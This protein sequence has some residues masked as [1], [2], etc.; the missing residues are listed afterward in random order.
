[1]TSGTQWSRFFA[2]VRVQGVGEVGRRDLPDGQVGDRMDGFGVPAPP[3]PEGSADDLQDCVGVRG[4]DLGGDL[5]ELDALALGSSVSGIDGAVGDRD[6]LPGQCPE[7]TEQ[8]GLVGLDRE[9]EGPASADQVIDV[10]AL[11]VQRVSTNLLVWSTQSSSGAKASISLI[12]PSK[13]R[14]P[15]TTPVAVSNAASRRTARPSGPRA[16]GALAV[17]GD[18]WLVQQRAVVGRQGSAPAAHRTVH[19]RC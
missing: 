6:L 9:Q 5:G 1:M 2:P 10:A 11:G 13:T 14:W 3:G 16:Q 18:H 4:V 19:H 17:D 15:R 12:F 7:L 8:A